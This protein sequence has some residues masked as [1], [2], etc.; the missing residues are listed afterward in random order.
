MIIIIIYKGQPVFVITRVESG[1]RFA[2]SQAML[3]LWEEILKKNLASAPIQER[4]RSRL[5]TESIRI[6]EL[7]VNE[8]QQLT[9]F[10]V[11]AVNN[12]RISNK[13]D[14]LSLQLRTKFCRHMLPVLFFSPI[15]F[16]FNKFMRD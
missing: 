12:C 7:P 5:S 8:G 4:C 16:Y 10:F 14:Q 6:N 11:L 3:K 15:N 9:L 1:L 13:L 2:E